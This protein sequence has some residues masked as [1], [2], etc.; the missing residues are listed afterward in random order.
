MVLVGR[1]ALQ[2]GGAGQGLAARAQQE[3]RG[4]RRA[5]RS[6]EGRRGAVRP[7]RRQPGRVRR[8]R[9]SGAAGARRWLRGLGG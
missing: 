5:D 6:A 2:R 7:V 1:P 9:A 4:P 3:D 8:G